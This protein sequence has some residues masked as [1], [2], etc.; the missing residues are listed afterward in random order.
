[1]GRLEDIVER[2]RNP[3]RSARRKGLGVGIASVFLL[4]VLSL[5]IFTD[6]AS[7]PDQPPPAASGDH[8]IRDIQLGNGR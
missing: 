1:M 5:L 4:I 7:P 2:N 6:L 3:R 8:R